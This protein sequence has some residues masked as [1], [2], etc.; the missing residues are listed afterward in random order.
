MKVYLLIG[1]MLLTAC[2]SNPSKAPPAP[3]VLN[4]NLTLADVCR[5]V[6]EETLK[7]GIAKVEGIRKGKYINELSGSFHL[8]LLPDVMNSIEAV[9][10]LPIEDEDDAIA[11]A[12][13]VYNECIMNNR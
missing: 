3:V 11:Y 6:Q 12:N 2:G 5:I 10:H 7:V 1:V 4:D 9:Y 13:L 8:A